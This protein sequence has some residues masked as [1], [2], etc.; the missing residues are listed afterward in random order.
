MSVRPITACLQLALPA[1][2]I[3][4]LLPGRIASAAD[5]KTGAALDQALGQPI[6]IT[7]S[8][9]ALRGGLQRLSHE[10]GVAIFLDRR[11]DPDQELNLQKSPRPLDTLLSE[12]AATFSAHT[13]RLA[14]VIYIGPE[15]SADELATVAALR[16]QEIA[17]LS[18]DERASL[19]ASRPLQWEELAEPRQLVEQLCR[20]VHRSIENPEQIPHDL[21]PAVELPPLPW[22][23]RLTLV[24]AGFGLTFELNA[25]GQSI[26][27]IPMPEGN[28]I[29]RRYRPPGA[30]GSLSAQLKRVLP[31]AKIRVENGHFIV[32]SHQE[33]HEKIERLIAGQPIRSAPQAKAKTAKPAGEL[34]LTLSVREQPAGAVARTLAESLGKRLI[35]DESVVE[36]LKTPVTIDLKDATPARVLDATL[37]PLGLSYDLS[38]K[39]LTI[40]AA[41]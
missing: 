15:E 16:R 3:A 4:G 21:W 30:A 20:E 23:D 31:D 1:M 41:K 37:H 14:A 11:I 9:R 18:T 19:L 35:Y 40:T 2:L 32:T 7:W 28:V 12:I 13:S 29:E 25:P 24:L 17:K 39:E 8:E 6:G 27:L 34:V 22:S 33:D 26:R 36:K 38:E 5:W 10:T